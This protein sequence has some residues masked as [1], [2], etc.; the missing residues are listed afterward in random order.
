M[1]ESDG[2]IVPTAVLQP[3]STDR[4]FSTAPSTPGDYDFIRSFPG[5]AALMKGILRVAAEVHHE[6]ELGLLPLAEIGQLQKLLH[7][8]LRGLRLAWGPAFVEP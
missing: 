5:H 4:I 8:R 1:P 7:L 3:Q 6:N 2:V